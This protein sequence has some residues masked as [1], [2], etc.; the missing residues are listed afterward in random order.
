M[1]HTVITQYPLRT[2]PASTS[3]SVE[4]LPSN[5]NYPPYKVTQER[6]EQLVAVGRCVWIPGLR[7]LR[8]VTLAVRGQLREWRKTICYDPDTKVGM[9]TMQLVPARASRSRQPAPRPN[10]RTNRKRMRSDPK[11]PIPAPAEV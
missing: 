1:V 3:A 11:P 2:V 10:N 8:E 9:P 6:A 5:I 7:K 4:V